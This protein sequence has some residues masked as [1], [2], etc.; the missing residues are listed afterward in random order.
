MGLTVPLR[1]AAIGDPVRSAGKVGMVLYEA[2]PGSAT[3]IV[4]S[5]TIAIV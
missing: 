5:V 1:R 4:R 3:M 2:F